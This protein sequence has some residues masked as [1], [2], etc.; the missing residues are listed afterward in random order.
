MIKKCPACQSV[1]IINFFEIQK[2]PVINVPLTKTAVTEITEK[3][4]KNEIYSDLKT[5]YCENCG[6]IFLTSIADLD[7]LN[8]LYSK[9]YFRY[10]FQ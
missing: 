7:V 5:A 10:I 1:E 8:D 4:S 6:H 9:Y 2:Y 3:Y